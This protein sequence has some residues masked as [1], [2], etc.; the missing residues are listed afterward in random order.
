MRE[1]DRVIMQTLELVQEMIQ[2]ADHGDAVREDDGCGILY[3]VI[4]D[5]AY[6]IAKLAEAE[7]QAHIRKGW[8][9]E[10]E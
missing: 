10:S 7:K 8:W 5:S 1:C 2:L 4:R 3:S 9:Q 6:K